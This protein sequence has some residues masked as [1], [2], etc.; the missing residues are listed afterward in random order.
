MAVASIRRRLSGVIPSREPGRKNHG[1]GL[2]SMREHVRM[3]GQILAVNSTP[4]TGTR[5]R[6]SLPPPEGWG[7]EHMNTEY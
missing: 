4:G 7:M 6:V 5:W 1:F 3:I 2:S